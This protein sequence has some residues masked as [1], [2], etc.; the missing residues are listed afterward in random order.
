MSIC[1]VSER[2]NV[3][4]DNENLNAVQIK[5]YYGWENKLENLQAKCNYKDMRQYVC[6]FVS[7]KE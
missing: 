5:M 4:E 6:S 7:M 1:T 2:E 3:Y